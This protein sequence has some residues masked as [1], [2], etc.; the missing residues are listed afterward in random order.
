MDAPSYLD[1]FQTAANRIDKTRLTRQQL[2]VAVVT[3][4][5]CIVLKI[6][7]KSWANP[8]ENPLTAPSRIF[9]A[10]WIDPAK[11]QELYYN[12]HAFKL[13]Q[14]KGYKIESRKFAEA[15]RESF[16]A[17]EQEWQNVSVKFGPLTLLQ[18]S[19]KID[20]ENFQDEVLELSNKFLEIEH[21]IDDTLAKFKR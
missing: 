20:P 13:R 12:I 8:L 5:Q 1:R 15:F 3:F 21:M 17:V 9:F 18:G 14:L 6:Y 4:Q 19:V 11:E 7:K 10:V 16:K 2:E